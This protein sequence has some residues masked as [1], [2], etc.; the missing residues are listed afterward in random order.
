[1]LCPHQLS[2]L[3]PTVQEAGVQPPCRVGHPEP[4]YPGY[5]DSCQIAPFPEAALP[6]SH[7]KL[8]EC[9]TGPGSQRGLV[10][11]VLQMK[12]QWFWAPGTDSA[13]EPCLARG[14]S[15]EI[16]QQ[17]AHRGNGDSRVPG[18][19]LS[20]HFCPYVCAASCTEAKC[21]ID[22]SSQPSAATRPGRRVFAVQLCMRAQPT[23]P[24]LRVAV[25]LRAV[26]PSLHLCFS[27]THTYLHILDPLLCL[28]LKGTRS[29]Q[30]AN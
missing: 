4:H 27:I 23:T 18:L 21:H 6:T 17:C 13:S 15:Q 24:C 2:R 7:P 19:S 28:H 8:G 30:A 25:L 11:A 26:G 20:T 5:Q 3:S 22:G 10:S 1:M 12:A 16:S 9:G 14:A 29:H